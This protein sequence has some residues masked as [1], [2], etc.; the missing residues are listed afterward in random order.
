LT[1]RSVVIRSCLLPHSPHKT[2]TALTEVH[3]ALS[4]E[5]RLLRGAADLA[6]SSGLVRLEIPVVV[7]TSTSVVGV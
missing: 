1:E 4:V 3:F 6:T 5:L 7:H 2:A